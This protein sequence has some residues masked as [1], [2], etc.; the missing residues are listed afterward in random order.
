MGLGDTYQESTDAVLETLSGLPIEKTITQAKHNGWTAI[1]RAVAG[2]ASELAGNVSDVLG[3]YSKASVAYGAQSS[4]PFGQTDLEKQQ[5]KVLRDALNTDDDLFRSSLSAPL[6]EY[7]RELR[8]DPTTAGVAEQIAFGLTKGLTKAV[9]LSVIGG[10]LTG[11]TGLGLSEGMTTAE[12]LAAEGVDLSTRSKVG[13]VVGAVSGVS[14]VLPIAGQTVAKT[15]ALA[16]SGGPAAFVGQQLA[17][18][19]ILE[20]ADYAELAQQYDPLDPVGLAVSTLVPAGFGAWAHRGR[21]YTSKI[22]PQAN[23]ER[24][25]NPT[26]RVNSASSP[27]QSPDKVPAATPSPEQTDALMT[28]NLTIQRDAHETADPLSEVSKSLEKLQAGYLGEIADLLPVAGNRADFGAV[29]QMKKEVAQIEFDLGRLDENFSSEAKRF[30]KEGLSR[31]AAESA[32]R[33]AL[34]EKR[35]DLQSRRDALE[36]QID[37]NAKA[38]Q[39][40]QRIAVIEKLRQQ[41]AADLDALNTGKLPEVIR[42]TVQSLGL[43]PAMVSEV[44]DSVRAGW[45]PISKIV[46]TIRN[47]MSMS[48]S[49]ADTENIKSPLINRMNQLSNERPEMIVGLGENERPITISESVQSLKAE[50]LEGNDQDLGRLDADLLKVAAEC[51]ISTGSA[52]A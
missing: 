30:Q 24:E 48:S 12:D 38:S 8:P 2:A 28:H 25:S 52:V 18:Q 13:G 43:E 4:N 47:A 45:G 22:T 34:G 15:A 26:E 29:A 21:S 32:A 17:I 35:I 20:N 3:A 19:K 42:S 36:S 27:E 39:A 9:G 33:K 7:A 49:Q 5:S 10:P 6:Y 50:I 41:T 31:Q 46:D 11:A 23:Q 51:F 44:N 16:F 40:Q 37:L 14:A 1:P